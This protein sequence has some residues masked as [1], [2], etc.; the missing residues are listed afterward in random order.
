MKYKR[1]KVENRDIINYYKAKKNTEII[2]RE[3]NNLN[4]NEKN[5]E[6]VKL[7][8]ENPSLV[9]LFNNLS[10]EAVVKEK[11]LEIE[12]INLDRDKNVSSLVKG[13]LRVKRRKLYTKTVAVSS[14]VAAA[15]FVF[16]ILLYKTDDVVKHEIYTAIETIPKITNNEPTL[17]LSSGE[18][19]DLSSVPDGVAVSNNKVISNKENRLDYSNE[20]LAVSTQDERVEYNT[21]IIPKMTTYNVILEDGTEVT[22]NANSEFKY[23]VKFIGDKRDVYIT[24]EAFFKV[25][26]GDK[27]FVVHSNDVDITVYGTQFNVNSYNSHNVKMALV[28]GQVGVSYYDNSGVVQ[29][30][31][32][33]PSELVS[34]DLDK[35]TSILTNFTDDSISWVDGYLNHSSSTLG[36]YIEKLSMWYGFD[37]YLEKPENKNLIITCSFSNSSSLSEILSSLEKITSLTFKKEGG[38]Y[39]VR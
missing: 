23:P 29:E 22:L 32:V 19:L 1:M 35:K 13:L 2:S 24:G 12:A 37:F 5:Q 28:S 36:S 25:K 39:V 26:K 21:L 27:P 3:I 8:D 7:L 11:S 30:V 17:I 14:S 16:S 31:I 6:I 34:V 10:N 15:I 38:V 18:I 9:E 33:K 4:F 20:V